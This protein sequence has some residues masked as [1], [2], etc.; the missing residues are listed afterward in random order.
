MQINKLKARKL[1]SR[2]RIGRGG[3]NGTYS[4]KG[5]KGQKSRSGYSRR[6]TWEGGRTTLIAATKKNKGFK[7]RN[8]KNQVLNLDILEKK[9]K[10]GSEI[11]P[12]SLVK[13]HLVNNNSVPVKILSV[14]KLTKK[15]IFK[16]VLMSLA[17]K[18]KIEEAGGEIK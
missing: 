10:A 7:S 15:F 16:D 5:M 9:F 1:K 14:G 6:S 11:T 12:D 17:T 3:T 2:K 4:G 18:K 13:A 8:A